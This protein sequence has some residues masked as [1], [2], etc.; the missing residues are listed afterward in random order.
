MMKKIKGDFAPTNLKI[1]VEFD[2]III[3]FDNVQSYKIDSDVVASFK[4]YSELKVEL[5][6]ELDWKDYS[7]AKK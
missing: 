2:E 1:T 7:I 6:F 3:V 5:N 4:S